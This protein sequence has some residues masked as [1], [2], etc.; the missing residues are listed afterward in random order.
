MLFFGGSLHP[1]QEVSG[2]GGDGLFS[3]E[4][5]QPEVFFPGGIELFPLGDDAGIFWPRRRDRLPLHSGRVFSIG[6]S[7]SFF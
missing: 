5:L 6:G 1:H 4:L 7:Y 2:L 3:I